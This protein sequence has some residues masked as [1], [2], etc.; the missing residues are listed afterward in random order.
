MISHF[1]LAREQGSIRCRRPVCVCRA[2]GSA[3][4][5]NQPVIVHNNDIQRDRTCADGLF[6]ASRHAHDDVQ[7]RCL[8]CSNLGFYN[9]KHRMRVDCN[10][11][12][13]A[14]SGT[15]ACA[16]STG[17]LRCFGLL[18]R[19][20]D[21]RTSSRGVHIDA[22]ALFFIDEISSK[23]SFRRI[24]IRVYLSESVPPGVH[25]RTNH[26]PTRYSGHMEVNPMAKKRAKKKA[27]RKKATRKKATRKKATRKKAT[28]KKATRKKATRRRR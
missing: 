5:P 27:T 1:F 26:S 22:C 19:N 8:K 14:Q 12:E 24:P 17:D 20:T 13:H 11:F 18:A 2:N 6:D 28:R 3:F 7:N 21:A 23:A 4:H 16:C 9:M 10:A 15:N 25:V